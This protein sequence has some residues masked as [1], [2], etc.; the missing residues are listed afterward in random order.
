[1]HNDAPRIC[2][3]QVAVL[4]QLLLT[5]YGLGESIT[6]YSMY[7][8]IAP[9]PCMVSQPLPLRNHPNN[10]ILTTGAQRYMHIAVGQHP[11]GA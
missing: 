3:R 7:D 9:L 6:V 11:K 1:M 4:V 10:A 2:P 8:T 5:I